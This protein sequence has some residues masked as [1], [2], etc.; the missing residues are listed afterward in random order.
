MDPT[1]GL[2]GP[3]GG[4]GG[5]YDNQQQPQQYQQQPMTPMHQQQQQHNQGFAAAPPVGAAFPGGLPQAGQG[6]P[7]RAFDRHDPAFYKTRM[8]T[9]VSKGRMTRFFFLLPCDVEEKPLDLSPLTLFLP[10]APF[11]GPRPVLPSLAS[12]KKKKKKKKQPPLPPPSSPSPSRPRSSS[13]SSSTA[14]GSTSSPSP[15][16]STTSARSK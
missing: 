2:G 5:G 3:G 8:C 9:Q 12:K 1:G 10:H 14:S 15:S 4:P 16:A 11:R 6:R 7:G 13:S